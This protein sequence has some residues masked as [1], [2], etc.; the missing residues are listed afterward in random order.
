MCWYGFIFVFLLC[1][2]FISFWQIKDFWNEEV[3]SVSQCWHSVTVHFS[4]QCCPKPAGPIAAELIQLPV[5]NPTEPGGAALLNTPGRSSRPNTHLPQ[6]FL[7]SV[8]P[9]SCTNLPNSCVPHFN[10]RTDFCW[11]LCKRHRGEKEKYSVFIAE[12][13]VLHDLFTVWDRWLHP[14]TS[15]LWIAH[16]LVVTSGFFKIPKAFSY[17]NGAVKT[18]QRRACST[19]STTLTRVKCQ[20]EC[21]SC[22][23]YTWSYSDVSKAALFC[24]FTS[25]EGIAYNPPFYSQLYK[26]LIH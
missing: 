12:V 24:C 14:H 5:S 2:F 6:V 8:E 21:Y 11:I 10:L 16:L 3:K 26:D 18:G 20:G 7:L 13:K 25:Q 1:N 15:D 4:S 23:T 9:R 19:S 22:T 17:K